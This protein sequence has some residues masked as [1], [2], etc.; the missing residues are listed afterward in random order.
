MGAAHSGKN[1]GISLDYRLE[2]AT[3]YKH[4]VSCHVLGLHW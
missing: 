1:Y 4:Q 3:F 2:Q